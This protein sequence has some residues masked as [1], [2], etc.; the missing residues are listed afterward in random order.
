MEMDAQPPALNTSQEIRLV[1]HCRHVDRLLGDIENVLNASLTSPAFPR[2]RA[3]LSPAEAKVVADYVARIRAQMVRV[4]DGLGIR[5]PEPDLGARHSIRVSLAFARVALE[6]IRPEHMI[7][8]G[9]LPE[10]LVPELEG[11]SAELQALVNR[12]DSYLGRGDGGAASRLAELSATGDEAVLARELERIITTHGLVEFRPALARIAARLAESRFEI[13]VFGQVSS[14]KSSLLNHILGA[15]ILPVGVTPITAVPARLV[16]GE[17]PRMM[18]SFAGGTTER[19]PVSRL[20]EFVTE[21]GNPGNAK[22]VTAIVVEY[23]SRRLP[24]GVALVDTPGLGSLAGAGAAETRSYLPECDLGVVLINGA[25]SLA[26]EDLSTIASLHEAGI[27]AM[28]VVSKADLVPAEER[29][30]TIEYVEERILAAL[31]AAVPVDAVSMVG[32]DKDLLD[33]WFENRIAPLYARR[34]AA[35]AES[36]RRKLAALRTSVTNALRTKLE[37]AASPAPGDPGRLRELERRLRRA[38]GMGAEVRR[39]CLK[40]IHGLRSSSEAVVHRAAQ[41]LA[42]SRAAK[43]AEDVSTA[44]NEAIVETAHETMVTVAAEVNRWRAE[45][46][47]ALR[48]TAAALTLHDAPDEPE[49]PGVDRGAP[50]ADAAVSVPGVRRPLGFLPRR[51]AGWWLQRRLRR[52]AG[53]A[54][55]EALLAY[56]RVMETWLRRALAALRDRFEGYAGVYRAHLERTIAGAAVPPRDRE[57]VRRDLE[58]LARLAPRDPALES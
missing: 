30:R 20:P 12:L 47:S 52:A 22:A 36:S 46:A 24:E 27:P 41:R 23:P 7:G 26:A 50:R 37:H 17:N 29:K 16:A 1:S 42:A 18:V 34:R 49:F 58:R 14:G 2:V 55:E 35:A 5:P 32:P 25:A 44:I 33:K 38:G 8:Y 11:L 39:R 40:Q 19:L 28:A 13:A 45:M 48:E 9:G 51:L 31:G 57:A 54:V 21:Q 43:S 6:E 3:D 56:S 4:L 53:P 15:E 10:A